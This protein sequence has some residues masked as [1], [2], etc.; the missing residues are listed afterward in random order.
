MNFFW[1]L[2]VAGAA[3]IGEMLI[4]QSAGR[5]GVAA[6]RVFSK[7]RLFEGETLQMVETIEN[8][9]LLPVPWM[10]IE[11]RMPS[12]L[13]FG[14]HENLE[15]GGKRYHRS[16]FFLAP[17]QRVRRTHQVRAMH[18]GFYRLSSYALTVGDMLGMYARTVEC[19]MNSQLIVY[20]RLLSREEVAMPATRWQGEIAVKRWIYPD[21]FLYSGIR[22]YAPGDVPRDIHWR[23]Y[24]RTGQ[25][26]VK[27]HDFTASSKLLVLLNVAPTER[28]WGKIGEDDCA[29]MEQA[30]RLAASL[31]FYAL[32]DG[33]E[34][35]FGSNGYAQPY[36]GQTVF[37]P[38]ASGERQIELMLEVMARLVIERVLNMPAFL[39]SLPALENTDV[40]VLTAYQGEN[41]EAAC[42][43]LRAR[44][45]S[46]TCYPV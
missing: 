30:V 3:L 37:L 35:G 10:R 29:R 2:L 16:L 4:F 13:A 46:V 41:I 17:W 34:A 28:L 26:K 8:R 27:Q 25:L 24:A 6:D 33:R 23:A 20:P 40:L 39:D 31:L 1:V 45:N 19:E 12:E 44:G 38:C 15:I 5:K 43:S 14:K 18:R 11:T 9:R 21:L 36:E 22:D 7:A 42:A 32:Q